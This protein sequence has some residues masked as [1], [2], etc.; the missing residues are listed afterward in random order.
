VATEN[1]RGRIRQGENYRKLAAGA[2][3]ADQR[4]RIEQYMAVVYNE[5]A[6]L[7]GNT[8]GDVDEAIRLSH[9]SLDI[10]PDNGGFFDTLAHCYHRKG[11]YAAAVKYQRRAIELE[12]HSGIIQRKMKVFEKSLAESEQGEE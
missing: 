12:P 11:D 3:D 10:M 8:I 7:V 9:K 1:V 4:D 5:F 2:N 6:W